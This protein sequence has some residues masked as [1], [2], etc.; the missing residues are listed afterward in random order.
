MDNFIAQLGSMFPQLSV[1][2]TTGLIVFARVLGFI[3][4]APIFN[5][6]EINTIVKLSFAMLLTGI[7]VMTLQVLI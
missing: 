7:F 2:I 3:R 6:K 1:N 5:R 4:L